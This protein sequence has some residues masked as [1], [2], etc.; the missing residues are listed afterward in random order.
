MFLSLLL[1]KL[2]KTAVVEDLR[3]FCGMEA[4]SVGKSYV[5]TDVAVRTSIWSRDDRRHLEFFSIHML[6]TPIA[7][8]FSGTVP[9][10]PI[11]NGG[12]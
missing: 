1:N 8:C 10:Q 3:N 5:C 12:L 6:F 7:A 9:Y 4:Y 11:F 2:C